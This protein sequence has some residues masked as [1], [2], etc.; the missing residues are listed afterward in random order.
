MHAQGNSTDWGNP[1]SGAWPSCSIAS[2]RRHGKTEWAGIGVGDAFKANLDYVQRMSAQRLFYAACRTIQCAATRISNVS[3]G[4]CTDRLKTKPQLG[5]CY[6]TYPAT[7]AAYAAIGLTGFLEFQSAVGSKTLEPHLGGYIKNAA[8]YDRVAADPKLYR[9]LA[10][11]VTRAVQTR[12]LLH[13]LARD[14]DMALVEMYRLFAASQL[15]LNFQSLPEIVHAVILYGDIIPDGRNIDMHPFTRLLFLKTQMASNP[16]FTRMA[17]SGSSLSAHAGICWVRVVCRSL[18]RYLALPQPQTV[19]DDT[20]HPTAGQSEGGGGGGGGG[21]HPQ[22]SSPD[23]QPT[24]RSNAG[25]IAPLNAMHPPS[26][27]P[28]P[29]VAER[30]AAALG[31]DVALDVSEDKIPPA[32]RQTLRKLKKFAK[33]LDQASGQNEQWEDMRSDLV[34]QSMNAHAFTASPIE[35]SPADGHDVRIRLDGDHMA[36]GEIHDRPVLPSDDL[37]ACDALAAECEP[38][39]A[40]L[41]KTLYPNVTE[42][43]ET[44]RLRTTGALDPARLSMADYSSVIFKRYRMHE[45]ADRKGKPLLL[46]ACDG[47]GSLNRKEMNMLKILAAAWL[48]STAR[49][50]VQV[51]AGLYHSGEVR[52]GLSGPLVQ[53]IYHP[54]KTPAYGRND[55]VR[56]LVAL[57]P[58]GTGVQSDALSLAFMI[59]EA[60]RIARGRMIYLILI[61]DCCWN[62][63]FHTDRS[64][65]EEVQALFDNVREQY[66]HNLHTTLVALGVKEA[67]GFEDTLDKIISVPEEKLDDY[68]GMAEQIGVYVASCMKERRR[69]IA[70]Q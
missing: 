5:P 8:E 54:C 34:E 6:T 43:V 11:I 20:E 40:A 4:E 59:D 12:L 52:K 46:I 67:T 45:K 25:R 27:L 37:P 44:E 58:S 16:Y 7:L 42:Q 2:T 64:G 38:I 49:L 57:P 3:S 53:W 17:T 21:G 50:Q 23:A 22:L 62:R 35:G 13:D 9:I 47:S 14:A 63:S 55:A 26:L 51:M 65:R 18:E 68:A 19:S 39:A 31:D 30:A 24:D 41:R 1:V 61:S 33:A 28:T 69:H 15:S 70:T 32:G 10:R 36:A 48:R 66:R 60:A 56:A 29:N